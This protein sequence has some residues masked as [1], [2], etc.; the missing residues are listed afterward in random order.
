LS[1]RPPPALAKIA[2][3]LGYQL[4]LIGFCRSSNLL[5]LLRH[6]PTIHP[7]CFGRLLLLVASSLATAPLRL[8]ERVRYGRLIARTRIE[9]PPV[10]ILGHWRSGT[11]HL[12]NL[13]SQDPGFG[14]F[15]MYQAVV[16]NCT[17]V[18]GAW[19]KALLGRVVPLK[20][21][22][23]EMTWPLGAPQEEE[24]GL[25][26][27]MPHSYYTQVLFPRHP[28]E[29]FVGSIMAPRRSPAVL[30]EFN[31]QYYRLLQVA[32]LHAGGRRLLLKNPINTARISLLLRL[33]PDA[34]FIHIHR[35]PYEVFASTRH[36]HRRLLALTAMQPFDGKGPPSTVLAVYA[37][38]MRQFLAERSLIPAGNFVE[39]A[40]AE[41]ERNP[42]GELR[43]IYDTLG[44]PGFAAAAP[45]AAGY[46][47]GLRG[48]RKNRLELTTAERRQ[49]EAHWGFAFDAFGYPREGDREQAA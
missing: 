10:F 24:I 39:V 47:A 1:G 18:G 6:A 14:Y 45:A 8:W 15:T 37:A 34:K 46:L 43:R 16:P 13:M 30:A 35:S 23:D 32:T 44:L 25:A 7:R 2:S 17:L 31:R 48:Y 40:Y 26:K 41:L 38:V 4:G 19:L 12:H 33:F 20:R 27:V 9:R 28:P 5:R 36:L 29:A 21:P 49:I 11:T 42:L 22:M 3:D